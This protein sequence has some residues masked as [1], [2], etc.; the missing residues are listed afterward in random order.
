MKAQ[1]AQK[2]RRPAEMAALG[3][4]Q[5]EGLTYSVKETAVVLGVSTS[6]VY[7]LLYRGVLSCLSCLRHKRIS[8]ASVV[9]F[10]EQGGHDD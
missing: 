2:G 6:T 7:R 3:T 5:L 10:V 9:A 8:R 4:P 1:I